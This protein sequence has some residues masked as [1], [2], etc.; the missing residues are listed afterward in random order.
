[1][2]TRAGYS[3]YH[4]CRRFKLETGTTPWRYLINQK[5]DFAREQLITYPNKTIKEIATELGFDNPDYFTRCFSSRYGVTPGKY[6]G[7]HINE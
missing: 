6:R 4:F 5:L 1:M 2:A 7:Q 3:K